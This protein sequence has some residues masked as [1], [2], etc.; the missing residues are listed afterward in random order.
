[1][2]YNL[3]CETEPYSTNTRATVVLPVAEY[4]AACEVLEEMHSEYWGSV[5]P[6]VE[7]SCSSAV[8]FLVGSALLVALPVYSH[9]W[10]RFLEYWNPEWFV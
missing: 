10:F 5:S 3:H 9:P 4:L 7:W 6:S 8:P 1:M 2:L